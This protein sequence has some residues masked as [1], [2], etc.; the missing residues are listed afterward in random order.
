MEKDFDMIKEIVDLQRNSKATCVILTNDEYGEL[1]PT[2]TM[3]A[4]VSDKFLLAGKKPPFADKI[5]TKSK[6]NEICYFVIKGIDE[7]STESQ[8]RYVGLVKDR[9]MNGYYLPNNCVIVFTV[10]DRTAL[11]KVS[12]ELYHFA[13][14]P[15]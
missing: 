15:F 5:D 8:N 3:K 1:S 10:K 9:E 13:V 11:K 6:S 2:V 4:N 7:L 12:Q 14:V